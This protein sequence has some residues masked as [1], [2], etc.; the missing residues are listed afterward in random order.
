VEFVWIVT[1]SF[2]IDDTVLYDEFVYIKQYINPE[3]LAEWASI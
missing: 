2:D 3:K 1:P